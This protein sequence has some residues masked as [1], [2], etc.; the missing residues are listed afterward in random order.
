MTNHEPQATKPLG[1][2]ERLLRLMASSQKAEGDTKESGLVRLWA[3]IGKPGLFNLTL[4]AL[5]S[6]TCGTVVL[7]LLN[8]EAREVEYHGYSR[9]MAIGFLALLVIY[10]WAQNYLIREAAQSIEIA[11]HERRLE[12]SKDV[13]DLSLEDTQAVGLRK[14]MDGVGGHY[15]SLSQTL[16][17]II[18]GADG[19]ILLVFMF[20]YLVF[21]SPLAALLT[22]IVVVLTVA[23][24]LNSR[25]LLDND[26]QQSAMAE[27]KFRKIT[28]G[29]VLGA[30]ELS[31]NPDKRNGFYEDIEKRSQL[32]AEGRSGASAHFASML[33]TGNS[34][35]Y[36]MAGSVVFVMPL[37]S[38]DA[39]TDISRIM[40]AVI[41]LLGPISAVVQTFQQVTTAQF[42]LS[43]IDKFQKLVG[44]L[45]ARRKQEV[46]TQEITDFESLELVD[47]SYRHGGDNGFA[48][49]EINF[50]LMKNEIIFMTGGNGSGKTTM[51]RV[52][53]GL[54]PRESGDIIINGIL[55]DRHQQQSYRNQFS[56][57]FADFHVFPQPY[58]LDTKGLARFDQ[59][60]N[61][62]GIRDKFGPDLEAIDPTALST[63]QR[64]RLGLAL[65]L[66]E[67]R[68]VLI[69]DEWAADQDPE[70]RKRFYRDI[71]PS[72]KMA[73]K[74]IL[75]ATHDEQYFDCCDRRIHMIAGT[76]NNGAKDDSNP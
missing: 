27:E 70:T 37:I 15:A 74:T 2:G 29:L 12:T 17:P 57:V 55:T 42:A 11:L 64:K 24:F 76:L 75:A 23:G 6:A 72:L 36:L 53:T 34:A 60:L 30:K 63:G 35:S 39:S 58:G 54:Y 52:L 26:M 66:A 61:Y 40:I 68:Q 21:L 22:T 51:L 8:A 4:V 5:L 14:V 33:A 25:K 45:A 10:R 16:V 31:L 67:D 32:L 43:E 38:Q 73:G 19:V 47:L 3:S 71:L 50:S 49:H 28:E 44:S 9:L 7:Y 69:L 20:A 56:T 62:L 41:F 13:L 65:A 1:L 48:I 46:V 18:A 59:W